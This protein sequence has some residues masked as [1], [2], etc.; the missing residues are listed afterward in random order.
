[1]NN[2]LTTIYYWELLDAALDE[3]KTLLSWFESFGELPFG[4]SYIIIAGV[5]D[6]KRMIDSGPAADVGLATEKFLRWMD[7]F[8]AASK[9]ALQ[10]QKSRE[11]FREDWILG[12]LAFLLEKEIDSI[13]VGKEQT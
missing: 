3:T 4:S 10:E 12:E 9:L 6:R 7:N 8:V 5:K 13:K 11:V 1:M 2:D